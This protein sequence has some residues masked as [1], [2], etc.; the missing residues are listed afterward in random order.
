MRPHPIYNSYSATDDGRVFNHRGREIQPFHDWALRPTIK[1]GD[2]PEDYVQTSYSLSRFIWECFRGSISH[3]YCVR[4][5]D[6][7]EDNC[8]IDNLWLATRGR[9]YEYPGDECATIVM[10]SRGA[11]LDKVRD[12]KTAEYARRQLLNTIREIENQ[13]LRC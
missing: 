11:I 10:Q 7:D 5:K 12:E 2:T 3:T 13:W 8:A 1:V 9:R 6:G 4:T